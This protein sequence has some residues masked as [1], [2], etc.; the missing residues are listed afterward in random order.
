MDF[1]YYVAI[2][3][4]FVN[5]ADFQFTPPDELF[6]LELELTFKFQ[7]LYEIELDDMRC[8]S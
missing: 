7:H 4:V 2:F 1:N 6:W 3:E 5:E 8:K